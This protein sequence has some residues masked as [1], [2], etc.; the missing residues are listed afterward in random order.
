MT[1]HPGR[2]DLKVLPDEVL[3]RIF[4]FLEPTTYVKLLAVSRDLRDFCL[5]ENIWKRCC[6][7]ESTWYESLKRRRRMLELETP[8]EPELSSRDEDEV[9][10]R[11]KASH[12][13]NTAP[14]AGTH[15][16]L[17][18]RPAQD[19]MNWDP[20]FPGESI[21]W[22]DEYIQRQ[23][24]VCIDWFQV[25]RRSDRDFSSEVEV[26][27]LGLYNPHDGDDGTGTMMAVSP[28]DDGSVCLWDVNGTRGR[29]GAVLERS[30]PHLLFKS[31]ENCRSK[32]ID[33][34]V[35]ES[36]SVDNHGNKAFIAVQSRLVEVDLNRLD[37]VSQESFP[38]SITTLSPVHPAIPITVG[39]S[40]ALF[41]HDFRARG[42]APQDTVER[43]D[44]AT[45]SP[46]D[47]H[48]LVKAIFDSKPLPLYAPMAQPTPVSILHLPQPGSHSLVSDDIYIGGRFTNIIH[49]DRRKFPSI[50]GTIFSGC[51][52]VSS[53]AALPYPFS[54]VD[55]EVRRQGSF[56]SEQMANRGNDS[57]QGRTLVAGGN[58]KTKGSLEIYG[59]SPQ[60]GS[61]GS[62]THRVSTMKNRYSAAS[63]GILS[64]TM[65][66]SRIVISDATGMIKWFER[67][68]VTECRRVRV[69][70]SDSHERSSIFASMP[71]SMDMARKIMTT[72]SKWD[73]DRL[74]DNNIMFWT[75]EKIGMLRFSSDTPTRPND[76]ED[77]SETE[78]E[79]EVQVLA[80]RG[81]RMLEQHADELRFMPDLGQGPAPAE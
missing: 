36:V 26:R 32:R 64:V 59:L 37:V 19:M 11:R 12:A 47:T 69:G 40:L 44:A 33:G 38:W 74:N 70:H 17:Q 30:K 4:E 41:L 56:T 6:F 25:P 67:D 9:C 45:E 29:R 3:L 77:R 75:G 34:G 51:G 14:A 73:G 52:I 81:R 55:W 50:M 7:L 43:V 68:G 35:T 54:T 21:S 42:T 39:T 65:Q 72:R 15:M 48:P 1:P 66:G 53:L 71:A 46:M 10:T 61:E 78:I 22:Y 8:S 23:G 60:E 79:N 13:T 28:L 16:G 49:Y 2:G 76:F 18:G 62:A 63:A 58:Y 24:P 27:G 80:M 20:L 31:T 5:D 57:S